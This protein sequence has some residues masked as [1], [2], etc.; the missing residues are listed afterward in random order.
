MNAVK[1]FVLTT[2]A[3]P[4]FAQANS[5]EFVDV[6]RYVAVKVDRHQQQSEP[7]KTVVSMTIPNQIKT[8]GQALN[9][10]LSDTGYSL[11]DPINLSKN[12]RILLTRKLPNIHRNFEY[13]TITSI[14]KMLS[15]EPYQLMIDPIK[16]EVNFL[17]VIK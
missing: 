17:T 1:F 15:G 16:R 14:L 8:V 5:Y 10:I 6:S 9:Y 2:L 4:S 7:L 3:L 11:S 13:Q 12:V